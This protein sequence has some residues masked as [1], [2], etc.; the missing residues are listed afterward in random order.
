MARRGRRVPGKDVFLFV[1]LSPKL[2][3]N[4]ITSSS[5]MLKRTDSV[6][7]QSRGWSDVFFMTDSVRI[8][9]IRSDG[10]TRGFKTRRPFGPKGREFS[11]PRHP[12]QF[13]RPRRPWLAGRR[14]LGRVQVQDVDESRRYTGD[15]QSKKYDGAIEAL[16]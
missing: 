12:G 13:L 4:S 16:R 7:S 2:A 3:A 9:P 10:S 11:H 5:L 15:I 1:P 8:G 6:R 14:V